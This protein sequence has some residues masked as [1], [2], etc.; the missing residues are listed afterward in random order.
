MITTIYF[1]TNVFSD[2][3]RKRNE[4]TVA[5]ELALRDAVTKGKISIVL[6]I[7]NLEEK[8]CAFNNEP[9]L[10]L[11]ELQFI[12]DLA[13]WHKIV[14]PY[15]Q[16]LAD[17]I[18]SYASG[19]GASYHFITD[20]DFA[21]KIRSFFNRSKQDMAEY[22]GQDTWLEEIE[23]QKREYQKGMTEALE[24]ARSDWPY[25][26]KRRGPPPSFHEYWRGGAAESFAGYLAERL[27]MLDA[28]RRRGVQ[29]L[30]EVK[31]VRVYVGASLSLVYAQMFE[32]RQPD[33]RQAEGDAWDLRHALS[34]SAADIFVTHDKAFADRMKRVPID[35]FE[36]MNF[37]KLTQVA[38]Y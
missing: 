29:G 28:C 7:L 22:L 16:L 14:K 18:Y 23:E 5:N 1:D 26:R 31:S 35:D 8:L 12:Q 37:H 13:D 9:D 33:A 32:G 36:V 25:L 2:I 34:A 4:V 20:A 17:D 6:S 15:H 10:T 30:L 38:T 3:C 24:K 19:G 21:S 11:A 27:G